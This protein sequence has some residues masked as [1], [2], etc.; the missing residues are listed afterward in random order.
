MLWLTPEKIIEEAEILLV[1]NWYCFAY[2]NVRRF[3]N[4]QSLV[5]YHLKYNYIALYNKELHEQASQIRFKRRNEKLVFC[6]WCYSYHD[7]VHFCE[8]QNKWRQIDLTNLL[9]ITGPSRESVERY[10]NDFDIENNVD[11][12]LYDSRSRI[13]KAEKRAVEQLNEERERE[14][15][16]KQEWMEAEQYWKKNIK[17]FERMN[18]TEGCKYLQNQR[19]REGVR[20][21]VENKMFFWRQDKQD[22]MEAEQWWKEN[23]KW[24]K[25]VGMNNTDGYEYIQK[26]KLREGVRKKVKDMFVLQWQ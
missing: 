18:S 1:D 19:L 8:V 15:Q 7:R 5:N 22:R 3:K 4:M 24:M 2:D 16:E 20:E 13:N 6:W 26:Q 21:K 9:I 10:K 23:I 17:I 11:C 25:K 14:A 12:K